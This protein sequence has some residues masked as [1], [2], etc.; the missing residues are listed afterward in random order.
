MSHY[1]YR[2]LWSPDDDEYVG[3]CAEF[4]SLSWLASSAVEAITGVERL[5]SGVLADL[6]ANGE[7]VPQPFTERGYSGTVYIRTSPDLHAKVAV[8]AAEEGVSV[9]QWVVQKLAECV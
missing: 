1:S 3:L 2:A 8:R 4:P 9:N 5:V 7:P 6:E